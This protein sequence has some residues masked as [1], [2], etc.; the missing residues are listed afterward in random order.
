MKKHLWLATVLCTGLLLAAACRGPKTLVE[1]E[2][3]LVLQED[4]LKE[5]TLEYKLTVWDTA[6]ET[7]LAG[8]P[9]ATFYP[10]SYYENWNY[11]YVQEWNYRFSYRQRYG[12]FYQTWIDYDHR[13]D[14]GLE[15]NY[16]LYYYFK[17]IRD[18]YGIDL[19]RRR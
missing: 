3:G 16:R 8:Q 12:S 7:Y 13:I 10:Q 5:D 1:P 6:F 19:I 17:F 2:H 15:L 14:Y 9:P 4:T 18:T 11:L